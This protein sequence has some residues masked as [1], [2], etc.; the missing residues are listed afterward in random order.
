MGISPSV[1]LIPKS[2]CRYRYF[3]DWRNSVKVKLYAQFLAKCF[4]DLLAHLHAKYYCVMAQ[5]SVYLPAKPFREVAPQGY[6]DPIRLGI[7]SCLDSRLCLDS[8][9]SLY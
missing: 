9:L 4:R 2:S 5:L 1:G 8:Q 7:S 6:L 3:C